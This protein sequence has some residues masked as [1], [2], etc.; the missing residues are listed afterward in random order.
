MYAIIPA[1]SGS[2]RVKDKNIKPLGDHPLIAYSIEA[3]LLA[4]EID[5]V[6]VSTNCEN[7]ASIAR[8]Y[9]AEV[10]FMRPSEMAT[11]LSSD[12]A[13]LSHFFSLVECDQ[14]ALIRP[15]S[16]FRDPLF[17]DECIIEFNGM[18]RSS[19]WT[20]FRTMQQSNH[21]PYKMFMLNDDNVCS[22]FFSDFHG[23]KSYTNLPSQVFSIAYTPNGY[24]DIVKKRFVKNKCTFGDII[25]GKVSPKIIDIDDEFDFWIANLQV[26]TEFDK[27]S[28]GMT[29]R[30]N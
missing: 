30:E 4:N 10:P 8:D 26:G 28:Y 7:I 9:G 12:D 27:L 18:C 19:E 2:K 16:P 21:S 3:C 20:G 22:G 17:I 14:V 24:I 23:N 5:R 15:T 1:R 11:G 25:Y 13:F 6:F 29:V